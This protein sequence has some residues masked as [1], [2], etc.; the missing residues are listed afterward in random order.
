MF[1]GRIKQ[2]AVMILPL[3]SLNAYASQQAIDVDEWLA[4]ESAVTQAMEVDTSSAD[5][6]P[7]NSHCH[8]KSE[9]QGMTTPSS[10][11]A[12]LSWAPSAKRAKFSETPAS[13]QFPHIS[14]SVPSYLS[15]SQGSAPAMPSMNAFLAKPE[16]IDK[17]RLVMNTYFQALRQAGV[18][19]GN[20]PGNS[21]LSNVK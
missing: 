9:N 19:Q 20:V 14:M 2:Y 1:L 6:F 11:D 10:E 7:V 17:F 5:A 18:S 15:S 8:L 13:T 12:T 3:V 21:Q 4:P 16:N